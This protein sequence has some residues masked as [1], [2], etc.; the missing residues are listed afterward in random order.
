MLKNIFAG[1]IVEYC[2]KSS[3]VNN[4]NSKCSLVFLAITNLNFF[5]LNAASHSVRVAAPK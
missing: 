1:G 3:G 5:S 4:S 2:K